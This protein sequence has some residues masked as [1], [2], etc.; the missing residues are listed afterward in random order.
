[1]YRKATEN[2]RQDLVQ[3]DFP[4]HY[5][6]GSQSDA[7]YGEL[8]RLLF[9]ARL[10]LTAG[11]RYYHDDISQDDQT[12]LN[13]P[14]LPGRSTAAATTPRAVVTWHASKDVMVYGSYS[15]GFRSGFPQNAPSAVLP[16]AQPDTLR[17]YEIG[18]K[19]SFL[20]GRIVS[21]LAV[22]Y[23]DWQHVQENITVTYN[24]LPFGGTIN[25]QSASGQGVDL[26][27]TVAPVDH[28]T[29]TGAVSWNNLHMDENVYS[30]GELLFPEGERLNFSA[31]YTATGAIDYTIPLGTYTGHLSVTG[32]YVSKLDNTVQLAGLVEVGRGD[33]LF[34]SGAKFSVESS[35][36][37]TTTLFVDNLN[38]YQESP[39]AGY[40]TISQY[41]G[42]VRPRTVGLQLEYRY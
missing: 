2:L 20:D 22:Y 15:E 34:T 26:D 25:G 9:D 36:N 38:N 40:G 10:A 42:R 28:L 7:V 29:V 3:I 5:A 6:D 16:P 11:L 18:S 27:V 4:L 23:M 35:S 32:N 21:D 1:M 39:I 30:A 33:P 24:G 13:A 37:W 19:D 31:E 41:M 17:N 12:G 8:T 14:I